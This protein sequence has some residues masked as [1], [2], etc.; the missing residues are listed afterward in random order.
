MTYMLP[1]KTAHHDVL[2]VHPFY[3]VDV[4]ER[5]GLYRA[6]LRLDDTAKE[7][8]EKDLGLSAHLLETTA[9][10]L[11]D[12]TQDF[13][14]LFSPMMGGE[15]ANMYA[16]R[17]LSQRTRLNTPSAFSLMGIP[18]TIMGYYDPGSSRSVELKMY[19]DSWNSIGQTWV[20]EAA[21]DAHLFYNNTSFRRSPLIREMA[22]ISA[23]RP[24]YD[25]GEYAPGSIHDAAWNY[26]KTLRL[27]DFGQMSKADQW[28]WLVN[29]A[30]DNEVRSLARDIGLER[31]RAQRRSR[32]SFA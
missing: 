6:R 8:F 13:E 12:A 31:T 4:V 7:F 26:L 3:Q 32:V 10:E 22:A 18:D 29:R 19:R 30:T 25:I 16:L 23:A 28:L 15:Q 5:E 11:Q 14:R 2:T 27:S 21:H 1:L 24:V 17:I 20:H 9:H